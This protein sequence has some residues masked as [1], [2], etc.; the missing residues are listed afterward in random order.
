MIARVVDTAAFDLGGDS[1]DR[2]DRGV[3]LVHGFTG[4]PYEVRPLGERLAALGYTAVGP[5]L[6][7]HGRTA[8]ELNRTGWPD[9]LNAA[10]GELDALRRRCARV[11]V[12]GLSLGGLLALALARRNR[13]LRAV[14]TMAAP[15]W[16]APAL[17][18]TVRAFTFVTRAR[19]TTFPKAGADIADPEARRVFPS[20]REF[21][22]VALR[23]LL[24][25]MPRVRA[26]LPEIR[27]PTLVVHGDRD[28][29]APPA[30]AIEVLRNVGTIDKR[31]VRLPRS[32]HIV[33]VD[34]EREIVAREVA[35]FL[36]QRMPP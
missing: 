34:V 5:L 36:D 12:V 25:F 16:I 2:S 31:L 20:A 24:D 8:A 26:D 28:H 9:W 17:E 15:L 22:L 30:C 35:A 27:V 13:D 7:G 3:L 6:P 33:T 29:T 23:S 19:V 14:V 4:T 21:P 18:A 32:C 1:K 11:A 10:Q